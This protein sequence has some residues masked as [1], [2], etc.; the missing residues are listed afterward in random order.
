MNAALTISIDEAT[1]TALD[2]L[3]ARTESSRDALVHEALG[4][5]LKLQAWQLKKIEEG[6]AA[7]DRGDFVSDEEIQRILEK[8]GSAE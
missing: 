5:F 8:H 4:N 6:L 1:L 7:A 2:D 3:A